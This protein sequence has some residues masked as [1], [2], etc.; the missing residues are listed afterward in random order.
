MFQKWIFLQDFLPNSFQ[1]HTI[2]GYLNLSWEEMD[3]KKFYSS[4]DYIRNNP[5]KEELL[6]E[7]YLAD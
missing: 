1:D 3:F 5:G 6:A 4:I 7:R 2:P